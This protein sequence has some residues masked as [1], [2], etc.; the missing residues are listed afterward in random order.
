MA[1]SARYQPLAA[2]LHPSPP[3][4][5]RSQRLTRSLRSRPALAVY[6]VLALGASLVLVLSG[7]GGGGAGGDGQGGPFGGFGASGYWEG[8]FGGGGRGAERYW[9]GLTVP[10][11]KDVWEVLKDRRPFAPKR[12]S[13]GILRKQGGG[14]TMREALRED[15]RY[16]WTP[17]G[18]G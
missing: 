7:V 6:V 1:D 18:A 2:S 3:P 16:S 4:S 17:P 15:R 8:G 10:P 13:W 12:L 11:G 14:A 9:R 5:S